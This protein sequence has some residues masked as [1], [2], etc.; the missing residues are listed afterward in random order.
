MR[1]KKGKTFREMNYLYT[2]NLDYTVLT[3]YC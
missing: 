2:V 1:E 3:N